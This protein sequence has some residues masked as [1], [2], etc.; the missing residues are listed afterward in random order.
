MSDVGKTV[1]AIQGNP[2][3]RTI[4]GS[5]EDGY[6]LT[7]NNVT[8]QNEWQPINANNVPNVVDTSI[9]VT[10]STITGINT[11]INF[12]GLTAPVT[13]TLPVPADLVAGQIVTVV[14]GDY[15][16]NE[17]NYI[18]ING[19]A[20]TTVAGIASYYLGGQSTTVGIILQYDAVTANWIPASAPLNGYIESTWSPTGSYAFFRDST[21]RYMLGIIGLDTGN[22][23]IIIGNSS[24][25]IGLQGSVALA[26]ALSNPAS[27]SS[28]PGISG[29]NLYS[30]ANTASLTCVAQYGATTVVAP[31]GYNDISGIPNPPLQMQDQKWLFNTINLTSVEPLG[32]YTVPNSDNLGSNNNGGYITLTTQAK[33]ATDGYLFS[34][35]QYTLSYTYNTGTVT[36]LNDGTLSL[37]SNSNQTS[38]TSFIPPVVTATTSG[39]T[40]NFS[41][42]VSGSAEITVVVSS[43]LQNITC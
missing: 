12:H 43:L 35:S 33:C 41:C 5:T 21:G 37:V 17:T 11:F 8:S 16:I 3:K 20:G 4:L 42:A 38:N 36:L 26:Q 27:F 2:V 10:A 31:A 15:S 34:T 40:I 13:V 23:G 32:S 39:A 25:I 1:Y 7:W 28:T 22:A 29:V 24:Q 18:T 30:D 14:C 6:V 19:G 9:S